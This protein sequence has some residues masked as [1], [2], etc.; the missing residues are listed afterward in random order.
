VPQ[1]KEAEKHFD[2]GAAWDYSERGRGQIN[3]D[4]RDGADKAVLT[5]SR[6]GAKTQGRWKGM[7]GG[8]IHRL[9]GLAP[10]GAGATPEEK[11]AF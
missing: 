9:Y 7:G 5:Q 6:K 2:H 3:R 11:E 4:E 1:P 8:G 10:R